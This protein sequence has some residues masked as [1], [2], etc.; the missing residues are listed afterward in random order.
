MLNQLLRWLFVSGGAAMLI[1][2]LGA[3]VDR[4]SDGR[5]ARTGWLLLVGSWVV[6]IAET[7][8]PVMSIPPWGIISFLLSLAVSIGAL[9]VAAMLA[10]VILSRRTPPDRGSSTNSA[11]PVLLIAIAVVS[12]FAERTAG[13]IA[14]VEG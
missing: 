14:A 1:R 6:V 3:R 10:L 7:F 8:F 13:I 9:A 5:L 4:F 12:F 2:S 11:V